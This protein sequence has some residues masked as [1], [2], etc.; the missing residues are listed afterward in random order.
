MHLFRKIEKAILTLKQLTSLLEPD[1][2]EEG[3]NSRKFEGEVY[4][5]FIKYLREVASKCILLTGTILKFEIFNIFSK[6]K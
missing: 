6:L 4:S 3:T 5:I 2:S 1:F